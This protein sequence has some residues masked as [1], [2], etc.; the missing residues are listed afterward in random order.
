MSKEPKSNV[1]G[2]DLGTTYS[3]IAFINEYGKAEIIKNSDGEDTTPS[4]VY[5]ESPTSILVGSNAKSAGTTGPE[6]A[7]KVADFVKNQMSNKTWKFAV[8]D[9][10]YGPVEISGLIVKRLVEDA[11][12]HGGHEVKDVV[13]TCPAYFGELERLRTRQAG[14]MIGLNVLKIL[15]EPVAAALNYGL[16][17]ANVKGQNVIVY[18]LGGGTFD[19]T[20]ISIG[21][22]PDK[23]DI[24]VICTDGDHQL[25]G[26]LW[27]DKI[28]QY[29]L[30]EFQEGTGTNIMQGDPQEV[31]ETMYD[32]R[33]AAERNKQTLTARN[34]VGHKITHDGSKATINLT[35]EKFDE[36]TVDLLERTIDL[37]DKVL[38]IAKE[39]GVS[40]IDT[41]LLV[42]GSTRMPQVEKR[43]VEKYS[44]VPGDTIRYFDVDAAVAK[45]AA[46][47]AEITKIKG[48]LETKDSKQVALLT[49]KTEGD[50][51]EIANTTTRKV[52][53]KSYGVK[54][55]M[56]DDYREVV[57]NLVIKQTEVPVTVTDE[58]F[59]VQ[60][61]GTTSL[62]LAVYSND[63][64]GQFVELNMSTMVG[65]T[66][67]LL[68]QM[69]NA[70]MPIHIRFTLTDE[71][72]LR[73]FAY[74]PTG[75]GTKE[76][77]FTPEGALTE[78]QMAAAKKQSS[79]LHVK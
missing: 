54:V 14:E 23:T 39:K 60:S 76:A 47:E 70:G 71:G 63:E 29:Y 22:D 26:K 1:Y 74:D 10:E 62:Q 67:F 7:Q 46:K 79:L 43:L 9:K 13:I 78:E 3:A 49:G 56:G 8:D 66:D 40:K 44:L 11:K 25:G 77:E 65:E 55:S 73:L 33:I 21:T 12:K 32:L 51:R 27:D 37:T 75:G 50:V 45:G 58:N 17:V 19:V 38:E 57:S 6:A 61:N 5:F 2:I 34:E 69:L 35:R 42:G 4:V 72:K 30:T 28:V 59:Q 64:T 68:P 20:V 15:D 16:E 18:D 53:T 36:M 48:M 52:A 24:R 31:H 41:F